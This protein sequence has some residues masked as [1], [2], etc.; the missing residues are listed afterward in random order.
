MASIQDQ[1]TLRTGVA[2][3]MN[4][5]DLTDTQIDQFIEIAEAR[6]YE[7]LRVP[8]LEV[9]ED[10]SV[11][12]ANSSITIPAGFIEI[13]ELKHLKGGT[14]SVSPT[15]NTTRALCSAASGTWTDDDKDDDI[16]LK[17][18]DSRAFG[19]NKVKNAYTRELNNF[20]ITDDNGEQKA[21]GEY[22][23]KFYKSEDPVGTY[24]ST[25]TTAGAFVVG[26]YYTILTVGNT[27]FIGDGASAN[28]VGVIFKATSVGSGTGTANVETIPWILGTEYETILYAACTVGSTFIGDVEMEQKFDN[29]TVRKVVALN[30]KEKRADLKGGIFTHHF[31]SSAI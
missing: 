21:S 10:F 31:S 3:W 2:D 9:T 22:T 23:I 4:R 14:C 13:I 15:T 7:D 16:I 28:T 26:K 30:D 1:V 19:N 20:L 25:A 18:I 12:V 27:N 17:R 24:S 29:L 11:A 5:T 6:L 8:T